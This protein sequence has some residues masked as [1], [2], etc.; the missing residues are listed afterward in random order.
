MGPIDSKAEKVLSPKAFVHV[1]LRTSRD[2]FPKMVQ[3]YKT[4]LGATAS[5]ENNSISFFTYDDEHH[6]IAIAAVPGVG[7]KAKGTCELEHI[8]FSFDT[9]KDLGLA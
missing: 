2:S 3:F 7:K 1:V 4:F 9:L 6:R 5:Y 8:A